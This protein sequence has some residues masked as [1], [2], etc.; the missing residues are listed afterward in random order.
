MFLEV[1]MY[2]VKSGS[3]IYSFEAR[4]NIWFTFL[5]AKR[6]EESHDSGFKQL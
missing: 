2:K 3:C 6:Q 4:R 5:K 1:E